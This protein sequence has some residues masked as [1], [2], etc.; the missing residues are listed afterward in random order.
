[1]CWM[2][3]AIARLRDGDRRVWSNGR[4]MINKGK[5]KNLGGKSARMSL[6]P[7]RISHIVTEGWTRV[8]VGKS[9]RL[10]PLGYDAAYSVFYIHM[11]SFYLQLACIYVSN[12]SD[13][14]AAISRCIKISA[15]VRYLG[16]LWAGLAICVN[17]VCKKALFLFIR[18]A[19][20]VYWR[21]WDDQM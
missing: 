14:S 10:A 19:N 5:P 21:S 9:Y 7:P 11:D 3:R 1:M 16:R 20:S 17:R 15:L 13:H 4:M 2:F 12:A 8:S 6:H 18:Y